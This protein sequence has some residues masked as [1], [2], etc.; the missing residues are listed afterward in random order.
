[1][2]VRQR[3]GKAM[4]KRFLAISTLQPG[5]DREDLVRRLEDLSRV[6]SDRGVHPLET[7]FS[8]PRAR[9]YTLID[10]VDDRAVLDACAAAGLPAEVVPGERVYTDVLD[11]PHRAR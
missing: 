11:E 5:W 2:P 8:L 4:R 3:K 9:A 1:M 7:F 6:A 10:A